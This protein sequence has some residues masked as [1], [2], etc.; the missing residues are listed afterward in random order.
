MA[1][2]NI[3]ILSK[4]SS[5]IGIWTTNNFD[6]SGPNYT[7]TNGQSQPIPTDQGL[8]MIIG[9]YPKISVGNDIEFHQANSDVTTFTV[10]LYSG[11]YWQLCEITNN[12]NLSVVI[13]NPGP[14][15]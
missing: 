13:K 14:V 4:H 3:T 6:T 7:I 11:V 1:Q 12:T 9:V 5:P 2:K 10:R 15:H 8:S